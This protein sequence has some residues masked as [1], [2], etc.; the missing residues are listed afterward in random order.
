MFILNSSKDNRGTFVDSNDNETTSDK[1]NDE[2]NDERR[3]S[4]IEKRKHHYDEFKRAKE[5]L[6]NKGKLFDD[7]E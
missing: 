1:S 2:Q 6:S 4:F 5:L 3:R 7:E